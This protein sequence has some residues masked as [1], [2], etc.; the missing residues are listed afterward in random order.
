M[1]MSHEERTLVAR[2]AL[3]NTESEAYVNAYNERVEQFIKDCP[4]QRLEQLGRDYPD[5]CKAITNAIP[6]AAHLMSLDIIINEL[7][8]FSDLPSEDRGYI[9]LGF[10]QL[11]EARDLLLRGFIPRAQQEA[12]DAAHRLH[13]VAK[14]RKRNAQRSAHRMADPELLERLDRVAS[15]VDI[16]AR[17]L[18]RPVR[19]VT[20]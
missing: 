2:A 19:L 13:W 5:D 3:L 16:W 6:T 4:P 18:Q 7:K 1:T 11:H 10:M 20:A 17:R 9:A 15:H 8:G 12:S 14:E